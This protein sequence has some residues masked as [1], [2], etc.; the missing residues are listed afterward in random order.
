MSDESLIY[1]SRREQQIMDIILRLGKATVSDVQDE[2]GE[3]INYSTVRALM[4]I[5]EDKGQLKHEKQ[6]IKYLYYPAGSRKNAE[7]K[8]IKNLLK[9]FFNNCNVYCWSGSVSSGF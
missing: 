8:A 1:L 3:D 6:G 4:K 9:T 5:L 7:K 2:I